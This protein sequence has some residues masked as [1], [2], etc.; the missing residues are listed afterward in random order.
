MRRRIGYGCQDIGLFRRM[1]V[2]ENIGI[3]LQL[4][5]WP[6]NRTSLAK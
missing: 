6:K 2:T 5:G 4:L 3:T 1:P